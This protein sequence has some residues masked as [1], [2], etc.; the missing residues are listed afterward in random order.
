MLDPSAAQMYM[1]KNH[2]GV[3]CLYGLLS[4]LFHFSTYDCGCLPMN[5]P[6]PEAVA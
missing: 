3:I 2:T 1:Y 4:N 5:Q 6:G